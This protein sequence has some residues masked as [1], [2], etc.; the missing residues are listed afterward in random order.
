MR[1][2]LPFSMLHAFPSL[3]CHILWRLPLALCY[4]YLNPSFVLSYAPYA[5]HLFLS[6]FIPY[7]DTM[8]YFIPS[9]IDHPCH[10]PHW[11]WTTGVYLTT[12]QRP[13]S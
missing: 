13:I 4:P 12:D 10:F 11:I 9:P 6:G 3:P 5:F 1:P 2:F 8:P 7:P